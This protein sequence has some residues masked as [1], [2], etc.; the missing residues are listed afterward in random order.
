MPVIELKANSQSNVDKGLP[1]FDLSVSVLSGVTSD[2]VIL[3]DSEG[4]RDYWQLS[5]IT[6]GNTGR[7]EYSLSPRADIIAGLG[8][9]HSW[10]AG[11]VSVDT[12]DSL[13]PVQA[14]RVVST[15]GAITGEIL[16]L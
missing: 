4:A 8:N 15:S 16:V 6:G 11:E 10:D 12:D 14:V 1:V 2:P 9:W 13:T 3:P 5:L 7:F